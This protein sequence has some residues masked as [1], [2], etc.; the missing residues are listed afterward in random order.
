MAFKSLDIKN[1]YRS[2]DTNN[3]GRDFIEKVLKHSVSYKRAVGFFSSSSLIYTS[4]GLLN[5]AKHYIDGEEPVIRFVVSPRLT[6]EDVEAIRRGYKTRREVIEAAMLSEMTE[7]ENSF[8]KER[9]NILCHLIASGAMEIKVAVTEYAETDIG[10]YHEKI[11]IMTDAEGEKIAF[12]GSLNESANAF[13]HNFESITIYKTWEASKLYVQDIENDFTLL[14]NNTTNNVDIYDFPDAVKKRLFHYKRETYNPN[15]DV[16]EEAYQAT[17]TDVLPRI[18]KTLIPSFPYNYQA[19]AI[20]NWLAQKCVGIFDM[21]TGSGKTLTAY[22]A[23]VTLLQ[24]CSYRLAVVIVAP[25]QHLVE[26]WVEDA[27][28]FHI[29]H[30]IIGYSNSKYSNYLNEL[31]SNIFEYNS[32]TLPF[33]FFITTNASYRLERV[34][35]E[36]KKIKGRALI[37]ADEAHNFGSEL[38]ADCLLKTFTFRLALSATIER[39]GDPSGTQRIF[40]YFGEKCITYSLEDAMADEKLT[41]YEY[42]PIIVYL[43]IEERER[44][45]ELTRELLNH[46]DKNG[47]MDE[48]GKLIVLKRARIIAGASGKL[49]A[50]RSEMR[51]HTNEY[52]MLIYCGATKTDNGSEENRQID[53]ITRMLGK[54]MGMKVSR[55]TS[56][57][58]V[59]ERRVIRNRFQNGDS[60]QALVAIKCLDEGVNIPG[61]RTAFI[62]ASSTNPREYVQRRGRILRLAKGK[63]RAIIYDFVTLPMRAT[64]LTESDGAT[65]LY[66]TLVKNETS[67]MEEFG[68]HSLN[69]GESDAIIDQIKNEFGMYD[70]KAIEPDFE[71]EDDE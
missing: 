10:M 3:I 49:E 31:K 42:H 40:D 60:L 20:N 15:I 56:R 19:K 45:V 53:D 38:M 24:R 35:D 29:D 66:K 62:L 67:R 39:Y 57:E 14:W 22:G 28:K 61:I 17:T 41:Q 13:S 9:L 30:M 37:V 1:R 52:Y 68:A 71:M 70:F 7:P 64:E 55:Y 54:E 27:P 47:V 11:G 25:Y 63:N 50:L 58:N 12:D 65:K 59:E 48:R 5:V 43:N 23:I 51:K 2:S 6:K 32:G 4:K 18:D 44:Y 36:L 26:Q 34:Q 33:F 46:I 21:A 8:E 69:R 16:D